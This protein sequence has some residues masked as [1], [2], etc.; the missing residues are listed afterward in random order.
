MSPH[1]TLRFLLFLLPL[2]FTFPILKPYVLLALTA[3][4][5]LVGVVLHVRHMNRKHRDEET[6]LSSILFTYNL[7]VRELFAF[8]CLC[9]EEIIVGL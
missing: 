8:S 9:D 6:Y 1:I 7:D 4:L 5:N 3:P 2:I